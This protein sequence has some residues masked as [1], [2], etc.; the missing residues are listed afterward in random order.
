MTFGEMKIGDTVKVYKNEV[1]KDELMLGSVIKDLFFLCDEGFNVFK[2][3]TKEIKN[4]SEH[5]FK[6]CFE[7]NIRIVCND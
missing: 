6:N 2:I 5:K 3:N 7:N 1:F 4:K